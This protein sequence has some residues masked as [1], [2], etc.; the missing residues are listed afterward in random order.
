[1]TPE[2][3]A[4]LAAAVFLVAA[5][6]LL[7]PRA[8]ALPAAARA[9]ALALAGL[10]LFAL[11]QSLPWPAG[12]V[13]RIS[14]AHA[15]F[16]AESAELLGAETPA[17]AA[18]SLAPDASRAA[19]RDWLAPAAALVA[20]AALGGSRRARRLLLATLL[21]VALFE[22]IF[23]AQ[24]WF[25][26]ATTIWG[27]PVP[28]PAVRLRGTFVN[29]NH[30]A[31]L[32]AIAVAAAFAWLAW[33]LRRAASERRAEG[34]LRRV[35]LPLV[36]WIALFTGL[37]FTGSRAGLAAAGAG[38]LAQTALLAARPGRRGLALAAGAA[39]AAALVAVALFGFEAGFGR[40][41]AP[42]EYG[43]LAGRGAAMLGTLELW[44]RF[45]L[46]GAGVG[47]FRAAFPLVQEAPLGEVWWHAHNGWLELAATAGVLGLVLVG[48]GLA[49]A[50]RGLLR[51]WRRGAHGEDRC[52]ALA[53]LGALVAVGTQELA[54]FGLTLPANALA[55]A[56]VVGAALAARVVPPAEDGVQLPDERR[57]ADGGGPSPEPGG[58]S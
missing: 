9:G 11:A 25:A 35:A 2:F 29:P 22:V 53:A 13:E 26:R 7:L 50:G 52:A 42:S 12:L 58:V 36:V 45:P 40:L 17:R 44:S 10:A 24:Q 5:W 32:L 57:P 56:V 1:V 3:A 20:A 4:K 37:A 51:V 21:G 38:C 15:R 31:T 30:L 16:A 23:G 8:H 19:A 33:S 54:D 27:V 6:A 28:T 48:A 43:S 49:A 55:L 14:P 39:L 46:L 41:L 34:K 47:S 18:L